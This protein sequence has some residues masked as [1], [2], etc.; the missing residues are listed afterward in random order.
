LPLSAFQHTSNTIPTPIG[1]I[2]IAPL[3]NT[4]PKLGRLKVLVILEMQTKYGR[5]QRKTNIENAF[6]HWKNYGSE[7]SELKKC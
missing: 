3:Y 5:E 7:F 2:A 4:P 6:G 1:A